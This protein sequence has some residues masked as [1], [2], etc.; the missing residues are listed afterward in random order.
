M[1]SVVP[2]GHSE[3]EDHSAT[4][5]G[6]PLPHELTRKTLSN[7]AQV[8]KHAQRA[9]CFLR[10]GAIVVARHPSLRSGENQSFRERGL[11]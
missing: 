7:F 9:R 11:Y 5:N 1:A 3:G 10:Q 2:A 8:L 6:C 4:S